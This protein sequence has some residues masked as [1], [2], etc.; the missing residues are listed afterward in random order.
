[1]S[2]LDKFIDHENLWCSIIKADPIIR[3]TTAE[4]CESFFLKLEN[5]L[6]PE[7]LHCDGEITATQAGKK[8][9]YFIKVWKELEGILGK[10]R[11]LYS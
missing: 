10:R 2:A 9:N 7:N 6:S 3:P 11:L 1:M 4:E 5:N 8:Y